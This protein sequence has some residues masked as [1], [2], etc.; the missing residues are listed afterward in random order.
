MDY[1]ILDENYFLWGFAFV[2]HYLERLPD[3]C[4]QSFALHCG[5]CPDLSY[6]FESSFL[7]IRPETTTWSLR[8]HDEQD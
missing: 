4:D 1:G 8:V 7:H 3:I 5:H 6:G 2:V